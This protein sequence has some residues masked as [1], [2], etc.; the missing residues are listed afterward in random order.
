MPG[1][2][3]SR[4]NLTPESTL[5]QA[6]FASEHVEKLGTV[7]VIDLQGLSNAGQHYKN[8]RS[9]WSIANWDGRIVKG[10]NR[11]LEL[12]GLPLIKAKPTKEGGKKR[13]KKTTP[14][15]KEAVQTAAPE[16]FIEAV[17]Q[18]MIEMRESIDA[19]AKRILEVEVKLVAEEDLN[20][21]VQRQVG[22]VLEGL[23]G[24][25]N[26]L[27]MMLN[28]VNVRAVRMFVRFADERFNGD[29]LRAFEFLANLQGLSCSGVCSG[30]DKDKDPNE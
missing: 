3:L 30:E 17:K 13:G 22:P 5:E 16:G 7:G 10:W 29:R 8:L 18:G 11:R 2:K 19:L 20:G 14:V 12:A 23:A 6:L 4:L 1:K 21:V 24:I 25:D 27:K 26:L 9:V 15:S 28:P